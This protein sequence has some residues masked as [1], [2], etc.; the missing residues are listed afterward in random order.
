[1]SIKDNKSNYLLLKETMDEVNKITRT[2]YAPSLIFKSILK[3]VNKN[4]GKRKLLVS[5]QT[6]AE[7]L[8][9]N[10]AILATFFLRILIAK[11]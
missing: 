1:M 4:S 6:I 2:N 10:H 11:L 8:K 9:L 5:V 3:F 7:D